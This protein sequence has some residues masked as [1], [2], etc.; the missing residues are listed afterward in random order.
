[1]RDYSLNML[2][3]KLSLAH[4]SFW[5]HDSSFPQGTDPE[6]IH[7]PHPSHPE[8]KNV[9]KL[10]L[11]ESLFLHFC[12]PQNCIFFSA[13]SVAEGSRI[14]QNFAER[15]SLSE[16]GESQKHPFS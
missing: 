6:P 13:A 9:D 4:E 5:L 14:V 2:Y 8:G 3:S 16:R 7:R 12:A 10:L 11:N 15:L 1:M